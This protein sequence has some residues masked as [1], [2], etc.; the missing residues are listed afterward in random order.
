M[1]NRHEDD[2]VQNFTTSRRSSLDPFQFEVSGSSSCFS[3]AC[4]S[5]LGD[6]DDFDSL[7]VF[8]QIQ[9]ATQEHPSVQTSNSVTIESTVQSLPV[10][11][12]ETKVKLSVVEIRS[13]GIVVGDNPCCSDDLPIS[14]DWKYNPQ[15]TIEKVEGEDMV[16][17]SHYSAQRMSYFDR[18]RR[19]LEVSGIKVDDAISH[20]NEVN[21][22]RHE[23]ETAKIPTRV[24]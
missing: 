9:V 18:K 15:V 5:D 10:S 16:Y 23:N 24:Q 3:S 21:R 7:A 17:D 4:S 14:L 12:R 22:S 20:K 6:F 1:S 2:S 13:Y 19:L 11:P 8:A